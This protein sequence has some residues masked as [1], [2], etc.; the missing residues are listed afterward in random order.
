MRYYFLCLS[1]LMVLAQGAFAADS[2]NTRYGKLVVKTHGDSNRELL[3][4]GRVLFH[5][6]GEYISIAQVFNMKRSA[7]ALID[8]NPG[9]SGTTSSYFFV[10]LRPNENPILTKDFDSMIGEIAPKQKGEEIIIDLGYRDKKHEILTYKAGKITIQKTNTKGK[11]LPANE[12][13]CNYLYND[14]YSE[15]VKNQNCDLEPEK[16]AGMAT[17]RA[18]YGFTNDPRLNLKEFQI[19]AKSSCKK[20]N[21]IAYSAFKKR[22]CESGK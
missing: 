19:L 11:H 9:G 20:W 5:V 15:Y 17:A 7:V 14:I 16:V 13:D 12:D 4:D 2:A 22:V 1:L 8:V 21:L 6:E 3:V 10:T 18:Y